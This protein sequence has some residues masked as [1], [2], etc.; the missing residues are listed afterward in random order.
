MRKSRTTI[1]AF[2][3]C[4]SLL[5]A[6][7]AANAAEVVLMTTGAVE[8]ILKGLIPS[9]ER[10]T[11]HKVTMTVL[12]TGGAVDKIKAGDFAD[13]ILLGPPALNELA[14]AGKV[15]AKT[16]TTVFNSRIGFAVRAGAPTPDI[17]TPDAFKKALLDAKSIGFSIGPS[18]EHFS[19][20]VIQKLGVAD[21][22]LPKMKNVRGAPVAVGVARGEVE[23]GVHQIAELMPIAG[24]DIVGDLPAELNIVI[25][26]ATATTTMMKQPEATRAFI[27][28]IT[29]PAADPVVRK[30]GM[31]PAK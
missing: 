25:P 24:V 14:Q 11:G 1:A 4:L 30:N 26:Y 23:V 19:K 27:K 12:G 15:D 13:L 31:V 2:A 17:T 21:Q 16:I 3:G 18:G 7:T 5:I 20:V 29:D 28:F 6:T 8:Q 9:F 22:L 10:T